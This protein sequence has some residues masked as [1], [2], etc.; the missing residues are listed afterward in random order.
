MAK[1]KKKQT[2]KGKSHYGKVTIPSRWTDSKDPMTD[3]KPKTRH[4]TTEEP[5]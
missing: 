4:G 2:R 5:S 3:E 1:K